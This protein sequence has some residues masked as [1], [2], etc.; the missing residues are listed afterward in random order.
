MTSPSQ[1]AD[2]IK[3]KVDEH[4]DFLGIDE[5]KNLHEATMSVVEP[6]LFKAVLAK[7]RNNHS[8]AA[9]ALGINR[10]TFRNKL[11]K[12]GLFERRQ[13]YGD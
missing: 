8:K 2:M 11:K 13:Q 7:C 9:I 5:V 6:A 3:T 4:I 10:G 1:V 12:Y